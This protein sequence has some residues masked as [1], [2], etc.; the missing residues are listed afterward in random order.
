M[1]VT[2]SIL[3]V[4]SWQHYSNGVYQ[5]TSYYEELFQCY[6]FLTIH[7]ASPSE[8]LLYNCIIG[9]GLMWY[10][11]KRAKVGLWKRVLCGVNRKGP[12]WC[13]QKGSY[14]VS[15]ERT[16]CGV[17]RALCGVNRRGPKWCQ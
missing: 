5:F 12:M 10:Q 3:I 16:L 17:N 14:V 15:I 9:K 11:Q 13:Q 7:K 6:A 4:F 1:M 2:F 8:S